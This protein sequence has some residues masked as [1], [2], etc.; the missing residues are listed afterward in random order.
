MKKRGI[1][2]VEFDI[3]RKRMSELRNLLRPLGLKRGAVKEV[4]YDD[5]D[6]PTRYF[7]L[8]PEEKQ[9]MMERFGEIPTNRDVLLDVLP[10]V[11]ATIWLQ[12]PPEWMRGRHTS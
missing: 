5:E 12:N 7:D 1:A 10:E 2:R 4:E 6:A 3:P 9:L 8:S 11:R